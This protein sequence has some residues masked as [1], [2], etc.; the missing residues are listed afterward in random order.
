[1]M[2]NTRLFG[3]LVWTNPVGLWAFLPAFVI[4]ITWIRGRAAGRVPP[5]A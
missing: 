5:P 1:M 4:D 3:H 2:N